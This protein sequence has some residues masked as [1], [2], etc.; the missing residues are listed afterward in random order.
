MDANRQY[1]TQ[2]QAGLGMVRETITLLRLWQPGDT[3]PS[4]QEKAISDGL[5]S[6]GTARRARNI[7]IEMFKPRFLAED[8]K[9]ARTLKSLIDANV[10]VEDL[11][12]IF[13]LYTARAQT[14]L[15]DFVTEIYWSRYA[16]GATRL[17]RLDAESFIQRALDNGRMQKRWTPETIRRVGRYLLGSCVD[18]GLARNSGKTD[19][20]ITRFAIRPA[21]AIYL[22]HDLH[23]SG[24]SDFALTRHP[25]WR[26]FGLEPHEV[27]NQLRTLANDGHL[28]VQATPELVHITWKYKSME[29]CARAIAER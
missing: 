11:T 20:D 29:D 18:F 19:R 22:A 28:I 9:A 23:F 24:L 21:V 8:G 16:A 17:T 13:F 2:L 5:F 4:L 15:A 6:R 1:T 3:P 26:L 25:D 27:I 14:I 12:Q 10:P 7:V